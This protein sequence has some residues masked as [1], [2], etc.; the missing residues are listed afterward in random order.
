MDSGSLRVPHRPLA[1]C[2]T[3]VTGRGASGVATVS[4][5]T[6][7]GEHSVAAPAGLRG[8]RTLTLT[9]QMPLGVGSLSSVGPFCLSPRVFLKPLT[10]APCP[11]L[12]LRLRLRDPDLDCRCAP[13]PNSSPLLCQRGVCAPKIWSPQRVTA[14][15]GSLG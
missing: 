6:A 9:D 8:E 5:R 14:L 13:L 10:A 2:G 7:T 4:R 1:P 11:Q 15:P 12:L 3:Q